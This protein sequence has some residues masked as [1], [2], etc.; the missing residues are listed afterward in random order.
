MVYSGIVLYIYS[1]LLAEGESFNHTDTITIVSTHMTFDIGRSTWPIFRGYQ[2]I[3]QCRWVIH[4]K[5]PCVASEFVKY[6]Y[7]LLQPIIYRK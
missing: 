4:K 5:A 3:G 7:H 6:Q 2:S 1:V